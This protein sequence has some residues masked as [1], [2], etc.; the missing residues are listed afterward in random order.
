MAAEALGGKLLSEIE[1]GSLEEVSCCSLHRNPSV[2]SMY[3][4]YVVIDK[5]TTNY[6]C[7]CSASYFI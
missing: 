5:S 6:V 1:T 2:V 4:R 3:M 7:I